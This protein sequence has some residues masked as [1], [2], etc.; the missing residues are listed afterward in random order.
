M[1]DQVRHIA[2]I[3]LVNFVDN[4]VWISFKPYSRLPCP[5]FPSTQPNCLC[6]FS[7]VFTFIKAVLS[8]LCRF[9]TQYL[10]NAKFILSFKCPA[11]LFGVD[12]IIKEFAYFD[13]YLS[14]FFLI[15]FNYFP[16]I[17]QQA[18]HLDFHIGCLCVNRA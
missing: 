5:H 8:L 14:N 7:P 6:L 10:F 18:I 1:P 16:I 17:S 15:Q 9:S 12:S 13:V 2:H 11:E 4:L 3:Q